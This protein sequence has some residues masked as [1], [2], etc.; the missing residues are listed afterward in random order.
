ML[1]W[2]YLL[3]SRGTYVC[4]SKTFFPLWQQIPYVYRNKNFSRKEDLKVGYS[5]KGD[6]KGL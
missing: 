1:Q 5:K 3:S 2:N 6:I 4:V